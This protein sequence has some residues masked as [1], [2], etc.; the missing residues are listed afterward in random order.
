VCFGLRELSNTR[1]FADNH[2][3]VFE[4]SFEDLSYDL[5]E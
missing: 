4:V 1:F 2:F 5:D 3:E